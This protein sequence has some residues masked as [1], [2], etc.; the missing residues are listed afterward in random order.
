MGLEDGLEV[1]FD[2]RGRCEHGWF[3]GGVRDRVCGK[4]V[5]RPMMRRECGFL[6]NL[7]L[8]LE[9]V[10]YP[11]EEFLLGITTVLVDLS[12]ALPN[13]KLTGPMLSKLLLRI[14]LLIFYRGEERSLLALVDRHRQKSGLRQT[15]LPTKRPLSKT[16]SSD[17]GA[18]WECIET[19]N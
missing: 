19:R 13:I 15:A 4:P 11:F 3:L 1:L 9:V 8:S 18:I 6:N 5:L 10:E 12:W 14:S 2:F 17:Q 16:I 7:G